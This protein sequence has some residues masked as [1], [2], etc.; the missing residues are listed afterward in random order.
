MAPGPRGADGIAGIFAEG[1]RGCMA[2]TFGTV[3]TVSGVAL[4]PGRLCGP[5]SVCDGLVVTEGARAGAGV[6]VP[7]LRLG[8]GCWTDVASSS[9]SPGGAWTSV[10]ASSSV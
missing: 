10:S 3:G 6:G 8:A 2:G 1:V 7:Y 9:S 5:R 4:G